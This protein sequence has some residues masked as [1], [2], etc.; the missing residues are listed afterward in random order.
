MILV[1]LEHI[2]AHT[3]F[4]LLFFATLSYWGTLVFAKNN[5]LSSL[6]QIS[7]IIAF[8][9]ITGFS[10]TRWFYSGHLPF[11]NL[12]ESFM[13]LSWS[14][15]LIH[16][17]VENS[18]I[19]GNKS[20]INWLGTITVPSA[21]LTH[22][23]ATL[24]LP[25]EMQQSTVLVPA[26]QSHWLMMHVSMMMLSYATPL[27]GS[28]LAI[29]FPVIASKKHVEIPVL[30]ANTKPYFWFFSLEENDKQK[31]SFLSNTSA[32][33]SINY[34]KSQ[35]T[36]QLDHWSY[37]IISLG[38]PLSTIGILS[39]AVWANEAWGS[40]WNWD[41][42]ETWALVTWLAFAIHLHTR[43]TKG[44]QGKKPAIVASLGFSI[45]RICHLGVNPSGKGL[46]SYGWLI[47]DIIQ[48]RLDVIIK[49]ILKILWKYLVKSKKYFHR[50]LRF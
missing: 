32:P 47:R 34:N 22:G 3:P 37:R 50:I 29:A 42:K 44:W 45:I 11:S 17:I 20:K 8:I 30:G 25:R 27:C 5:K 43:I 16:I 14:L 24:G 18:I 49:I 31:E 15:C 10:L 39:G 40:H 35:L 9:C 21:M 26:L 33:L 2:L 28:S 38:F 19:V 46:H 23:F 12:Y 1:T 6:G 13:F 41:P 48:N 4:F 36:Q 7:M